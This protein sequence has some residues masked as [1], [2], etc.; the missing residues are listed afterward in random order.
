[1]CCQLAELLVAMGLDVDEQERSFP[2]ISDYA[3][4][5]RRVIPAAAAS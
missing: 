2:V 1:M 4:E 5:I 3:R